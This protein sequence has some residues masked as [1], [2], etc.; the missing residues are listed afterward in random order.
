MRRRQTIQRS[1]IKG[2]IEWNYAPTD[3]QRAFH[4]STARFKLF[5]G[6]MGGGKSYAL[7]A[8]CIDLCLNYEGNRGSDE[9]LSL[10]HRK[11]QDNLNLKTH[12]VS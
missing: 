2:K 7:C 6:A 11:V 10:D 3:R 12:P 5:G 4:S 1:R 8:E 9:Q